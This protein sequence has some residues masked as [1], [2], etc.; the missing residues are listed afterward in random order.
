MPAFSAIWRSGCS[1]RLQHDIDA[2]LHIGI[3]VAQLADS[4]LGAQQRHAAARHD[5]FLD[6]RAGGVERV[7]NAVLL[8]LD[9]DLGGAA[10]ADYRNA[11]GEL[12][13]PLLQLFAIVIGGGLLDLGLDL[14]DTGFDV[15]L[16]A[17]AVDDRGLLLLDHDF[18]GA[19]EHRWGDTLQLDAEVF[20]NELAAGEDGDVLEHRLAAIAE[21]GRL[22]GGDFRPP[23][24]LL[25]T[26][27]ASA[28]PSMSS[29]IMSSG[30]PAC[31]TASSTGSMAWSCPS[32][33]SCSST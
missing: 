32:F 13:Q 3:V 5:A 25:T 15:L 24:S 14:A 9:L 16:L 33:F 30:L 27:V 8:L 31:T 6:R 28:S 10:D 22:H 2:G 19:A 7:L 21:A 17:G 20:G 18:L 11:A 23:R 12:G 29:A 4:F 26:S 1:D